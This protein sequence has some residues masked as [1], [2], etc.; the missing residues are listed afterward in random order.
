MNS[1]CLARA[2]APR[3]LAR[4]QNAMTC[5]S[6]NNTTYL[7]LVV[8]TALSLC[9]TFQHQQEPSTTT[10][11]EPTWDEDAALADY[12]DEDDFPFPEQDEQAMGMSEEERAFQEFEKTQ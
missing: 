8:A 11:E 9:S 3:I 6:I 2:A 10:M 12:M 5:L 1:A 4:I 7:N